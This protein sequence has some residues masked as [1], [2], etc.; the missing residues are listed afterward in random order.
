MDFDAAV[1]SHSEWKLKLSTYITKPDGSLT[2]AVIRVDNRC[3]LGQW[4]YG[5]AAAHSD[6]PEF[7][8]LKTKHARFHLVAAKIVERADRGEPNLRRDLE[9]GS[10]YAQC[11][12]AC[13]NAI[14]TFK[15][16]ISSSP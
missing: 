6:L 10:E 16:K 12:A 1:R 4:I 13:V 11:S 9:W 14:T 5:E 3:A 15:L 2:A 8:D 7:A